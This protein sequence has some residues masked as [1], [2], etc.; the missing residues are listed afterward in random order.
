MRFKSIFWLFNIVVFIAL[1][2]I[3]AGS[4][5]ILGEDSISLFWKN[6]WFMIVVFAAVVGILDAYFIRN[7]KLFTYLENEDWASL[8][9]W[10]EEQLY[11]KHR[12]NQAYAN[13]LINTALTVSNYESVKKLEKEIRTRKPVLL[14]HVGVSLGIPLFRER[15]A[16][17]IKN[18]YGPL[19]EDPKTKQR[20]W[21]KWA[22]AQASGE[23]GISELTEL[24]DDRDP[25]VVLLSINVLENYLSVLDDNT[26]YKLQETK[27]IM[28]EKLKGSSGE[29][30][31]N[32]SREENLLASVLS[33]WVEQSRKRLLGLPVQ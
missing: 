9:A 32:R 14:R 11:I 4:I 15:N 25:A 23:N 8:L 13:L 6:M 2:V 7:W 24:L 19:A 26:L 3:V 33:S 16:E 5:I 12:L 22:N 17:A 31:L 10:L 18:F 21:A 20:S 28:A 27:N 29:K 1:A 30:L